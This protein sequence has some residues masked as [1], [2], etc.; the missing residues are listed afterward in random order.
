M[1]TVNELCSR[2]L[3]NI[4]SHKAPQEDIQYENR[5]W[6]KK[7]V[8]SQKYH[9]AFNDPK[10]LITALKKMS[11]KNRA[12]LSNCYNIFLTVI[13]PN[14]KAVKALFADQVIFDYNKV[15]KSK[16]KRI[17][18]QHALEYFFEGY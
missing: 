11:K 3:Y 9:Y 6:F 10:K 2:L 8:R 13:E 5:K 16:V 18:L 17:P 15:A 14:Q 1:T 12:E 4:P 7:L